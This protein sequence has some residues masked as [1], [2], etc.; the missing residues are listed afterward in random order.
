MAFAIRLAVEPVR[1]LAFG[2][3]GGAYTGI[4]TQMT[5][6]IRIFVLQNL[7]DVTLMFSLNGIDDNIPLPRNGY[8]LLDITSNRGMANEYM[9]AQG[10]RVYVQ[11]PAGLP[12]TGAVYLTT[13][14]GAE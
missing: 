12:T 6:P 11:A 3:I 1:K 14:Y 8:M 2:A 10:S 9:L 7:T 4:G 13:F 5:R